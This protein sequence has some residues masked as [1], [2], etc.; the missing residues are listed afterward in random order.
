MAVIN[1]TNDVDMLGGYG[2]GGGDEM[3]G[4]GADDVLIGGPGADMIDGGDGI[5]TV[6]YSISDAPVRIELHNGVGIGFGGYAEGDT[7]INVEK[8]IGSGGDDTFISNSAGITLE[9]GYGSDVYILSNSDVQI[10]EPEG[11]EI[12]EVRTTAQSMSLAQNI[13]KLT[14]IGTDDFTGH[15]NA[16]WN[17]VAGG[18]GNDL[19]LGGEGDDQLI[20]GAGNDVLL[21]G[22]GADQL[23]GGDGVDTVSY[24]DSPEGVFIDLKDGRNTGFAEGDTY[25]DIEGIRGSNVGDR[26]SSNEAVIAFDGGDGFDI[27]DYSGSFE[28]VNIDIREG[29]SVLKGGDAEGDTLTNVEQII[30][31]GQADT[32]SS[33][34]GGINFEGNG[35]DDIYIISAPGVKIIEQE[36]GGTDELYTSWSVM[37]MDPF[38]ER[39]TYTGTGDFT[40]F[41]NDS[42]NMIFGGAGND[43]LFGGAGWDYFNGGDGVDVVSYGDSRVA[44]TLNWVTGEHSGIAER[45]YYENVEM[46]RGSDFNDIFYSV[47]HAGMIPLDGAGGQDLVSYKDW[48]MGV[49]LDL[50]GEVNPWGPSASSFTGIE[51]FEGSAFRDILSGS[52]SDDVFV[53]GAGSDLID[54]RDGQ[55]SAW[56]LTSAEAVE[57]NLQTGINL[58]GD[59]QDDVLTSIERVMGS[60]FNDTLIGDAA[61][62]YL[63]GGQGSDVIYGGD[64][65][66]YINGGLVSKIGPFTLDGV[67]TGLQADTLYGGDGDDVI[68]SAADDLGSRAFGEAGNDKISVVG[69]AADGGEGNDVLTGTGFNYSLFG[70]ADNDRLILNLI[71]ESGG[72]AQSSGGF[73]NGGEGDDMYVVNTKGLVTIQDNGT[74]LNDTLVLTL[75][76]N[77][78]QLNVTRV[79]NDA[80]LRGSGDSWAETPD[81]GVKLKDWY[82]GF[83]TLE[84]I[85]TADGQIMNLPTSGDAF[86]MFG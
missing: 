26:F 6:D 17:I 51:L 21:G 36:N 24:A 14:Y 42:D 59:A 72:S 7:L 9:G 55:D 79:G 22:A 19:L 11:G 32:F 31:T 4:F 71:S 16:G 80:Y 37:T 25:A 43:L 64:G 76:D 83:N 3:Y 34:I 67:A 40:G 69:G 35:G 49:E 57:V 81:S 66:D 38:I 61:D 12:D 45:D 1:G 20:G 2:Q 85:Q 86:A 56:Y 13:E 30:G 23:I 78:A 63:E 73:A 52:D 29:S 39:M 8:I 68:V 27:V 46:I 60:H 75:I 74:S 54:G 15:G 47:G 65:A 10:I 48:I 58:G 44:V 62:N 53:G 33:A 70:G 5:D 50:K 18:S 77:I 41:G 82:A 84:H 28:P